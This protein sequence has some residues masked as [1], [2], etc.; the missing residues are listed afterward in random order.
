MDI[1]G[2][3][4]PNGIGSLGTG[5]AN[6]IIGRLQR[7]GASNTICGQ[8]TIGAIRALSGVS[9]K[10]GTVEY[11]NALSKVASSLK[12]VAELGAS[13]DTL[14][15]SA[16]LFQLVADLA[17]KGDF[18]VQLGSA[19]FGGARN[20]FDAFFISLTVGSL[21]KASLSQLSA[22][23]AISARLTHDVQ[24]L[25]AAKAQLA[26]CQSKPTP[27]QN[28]IEGSMPTDIEACRH[29]NEICAAINGVSYCPGARSLCKLCIGRRAADRASLPR[30]LAWVHTRE[31]LTKQLMDVQGFG[32][33]A[34]AERR[35]ISN[36]ITAVDGQ[37]KL[38]MNEEDAQ[39]ESAGLMRADRA[40]CGV[41]TDEL[42]LGYPGTL[43]PGFYYT[44]K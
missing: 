30:K 22:V 11:L 17:G 13:D 29:A 39:L 10:I 33:E 14:E 1:A 9:D 34:D 7:S 15:N 31:A 37:E 43:P 8:A 28:S 3:H 42:W 36:Q 2:F 27:R 25:Q 4:L 12:D 20:E 44:P 41:K 35:R 18:A 21:A 6:T 32:P 24:A 23:K 26:A 19:I 5:Q 38:A 16:S 40:K